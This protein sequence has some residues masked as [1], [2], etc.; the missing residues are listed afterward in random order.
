MIKVNE[1]HEG[2]VK[3]LGF[4]LDGVP[5][6]AGVLSPGEYSFT[7]EKAEHSTITAGEFKIRLP[8]EGWKLVKAGDFFVI[9]AGKAFDLKVSKP[10]SYI[11]MYK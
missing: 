2:K 8:G 6:T 3:S 7:T 4:E 5:Y 9:P 10:A 1:Y 11:C